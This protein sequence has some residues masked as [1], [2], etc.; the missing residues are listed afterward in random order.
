MG[1]HQQL[2]TNELYEAC[3]IELQTINKISRSAIRLRAIASAKEHGLTTVAKV[4]N[5]SCNTLRTWIKT[6][7]Y[8]A[9]NLEY[10]SGR[11]RKSKIEDHH[12]KKISE[13][14]AED[15]NLTI[16]KIVTKLL[17]EYALES[18][19]SAVHRALHKLNLSYITPRPRHYKQDTLARDEFKKKS[20]DKDRK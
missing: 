9:D 16:A 1:M 7:K 12:L 11:G 3:C 19:K 18:S 17:T 14:V 15:C 10:E 5:V 2:I 20:K 6:Y 4:F 13:W 8:N